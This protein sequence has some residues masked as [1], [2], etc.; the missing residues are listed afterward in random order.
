MIP[1][2]RTD[3]DRPYAAGDHTS[4]HTP[5]YRGDLFRSRVSWGAIFAGTIVG[6]GLMLLLSLLGMAIG[7]SAI[8]FGGQ[9]SAFNGIPTGAAIW[10]AISQLVA[11][12]VGGFV[13]GRLAAIPKVLSS[14]LHGAVVWAL[15]SLLI[16]YTATSAIGSL[17]GGATSIVG[18][19]ASGAGTMVSQAAP[20]AAPGADARRR[21]QGEADQMLNNVL[22][23]SEQD[24][25]SGAVQSAASDIARDPGNAK[26]E[27]DQMVNQLFGRGGVIGPD[28]RRQAVAV[29]ARRTGM[30]QAQ[31]EA[32]VDRWQQQIQSTANA[33]GARAQT[34]GNNAAS[35]LASTAFWAFIASLV[36]LIAAAGAAILGRPGSHETAAYA[37][38]TSLE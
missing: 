34:I 5:D 23:P 3:R 33:A 30:S 22:S 36:G 27:I 28:D 10:L 29:L 15:A 13:A 25:A 35:T 32:T 14:S 8:D 12:G 17:V 21:I 31:A 4:A 24:R 37:S 2:E 11:L 18:G 16:L 20:T 26:A 38:G 19:L 7:F 6:L 1:V 9:E